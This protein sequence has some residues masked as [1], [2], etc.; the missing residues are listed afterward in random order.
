MESV[1]FPVLSFCVGILCAPYLL[2]YNE[3]GG[4]EDIDHFPVPKFT[5]RISFIPFNFFSRNSWRLKYWKKSVRD[6]NI[7]NMAFFDKIK[8]DSKLI[9]QFMR[10]ALGNKAANFEV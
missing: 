10:Y 8:S 1:F 2:T 4:D 3:V 6:G 7:P 9:Y 5:P